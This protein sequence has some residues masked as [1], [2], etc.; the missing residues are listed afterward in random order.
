MEKINKYKINFDKGQI[1]NKK[2]KKNVGSLNKDGYISKNIK[3]NGEKLF[4]RIIYKTFYQTSCLRKDW[5]I[6]HINGIRTDN[7]IVNL[8]CITNIQNL[9]LQQH[10]NKSSIYNGVTFR[11]DTK[12][13]R[14]RYGKKHLGNFKTETEAYDK[15]L[16]YH[17][18]YHFYNESFKYG[19]LN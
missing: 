14:C 6:D 3:L 4:H 16:D 2:Y 5:V 18:K 7:R 15:Y 19:M 17:Y 10:K 13:W 11:N 1:Y 12:T 8:R 9:Q